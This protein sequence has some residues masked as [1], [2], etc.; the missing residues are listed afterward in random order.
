VSEEFTFKSPTGIDMIGKEYGIVKYGSDSHLFAQFY[1][2]PVHNPVKSR[3]HGS[4][5]S[6]SQP[7][8]KIQQ[9]GELLQCIDRPVCDEDKQRFSHQWRQ[10]SA[11]RDA[12]Q[13]QEGTPIELL[14][15]MHPHMAINLRSAGIHTIEHCANMTAHA[16][17]TLG[18]GAMD[19]KNRANAFLDIGKGGAGY[20]KLR[21]ENE[22]LKRTVNQLQR[23]IQQLQEGYANLERLAANPR[24]MPVP[25]AMFPTSTPFEAPSAAMQQQMAKVMPPPAEVEVAPVQKKVHSTAPKVP[26][27]KSPFD[28]V[29]REDA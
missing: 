8:I 23:Q 13:D 7:F 26:K 3:E 16:M 10:F 29:P 18:M 24:S 21:G 5:I 2:R 15:P 12:E 22:D 6:D 1:M 27:I 4:P 19:H 17:D 11:N 20:H 28:N 9:P 14:Y 25:G